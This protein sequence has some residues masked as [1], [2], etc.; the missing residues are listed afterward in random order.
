MKKNR[1]LDLEREEQELQGDE[2]V[3][4]ATS[5]DCIYAVPIDERKDYL[6]LGERQ[7][8]RQDWMDCVTRGVINILEVKFTYS[9]RKGLIKPKNALWLRQNGYVVVRD[10][11]EYVEFSDRFIAIKSGTT[12]DGN[13]MKNPPDAVRKFGLIPRGML[14]PNKKM[15][16]ADYH[17]ANDITREME[18]LGQEFIKRWAL[19]YE[20]VA[21]SNLQTLI[22]R[23]CANLAGFAWPEPD[24]NGVYPYTEGPFTHAFMAFALPLTRIFDNYEDQ[25]D[26]DWIKTLAPDYAF[27]RYGY[28]MFVRAELTEDEYKNSLSLLARILQ[29]F[30]EILEGIMPP[31]SYDQDPATLPMN[32][33]DEVKKKI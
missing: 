32:Q 11:K 18:A 2:W 19:N 7:V 21:L 8:G 26:G 12:R 4:G 33:P 16:W 23:D 28:R 15:K 25:H 6:P 22:K 9:L 10:G 17:N 3:F 20:Q 31:K 29:G 27:Y 30:K 14:S 24:N 5:P 1:G 13:S